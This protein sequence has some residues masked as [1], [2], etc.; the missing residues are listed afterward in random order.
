MNDKGGLLISER[1]SIA[2]SMTPEDYV[3]AQRLHR[4]STVVGCDIASGVAALIG[5]ALWV[6]GQATFGSALLTCGISGIVA[7]LV[8]DLWL[9]PRRDRQRQTRRGFLN[10]RFTYTWNSEKLAAEST[11]WQS[12]RAWTDYVQFKESTAVLLLY[13]PDSTYEIFPKAWFEDSKQLDEFRRYAQQT[14]SSAGSTV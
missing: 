6:S 9:L 8:L 2:G 1:R 4:H 5:I 10:A 13:P 14:H 12:E 11:I 3:N 7:V